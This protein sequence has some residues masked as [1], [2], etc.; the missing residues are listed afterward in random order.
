MPNALVSD[1]HMSV[2]LLKK[3]FQLLQCKNKRVTVD[4]GLQFIDG[5]KYVLNKLHCSLIG[6][7]ELEAGFSWK[8]TYL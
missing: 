7:R 6:A 3:F 1:F 4:G 2:R 8:V 5:F